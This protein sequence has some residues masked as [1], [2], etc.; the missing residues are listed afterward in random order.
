MFSIHTWYT[1]L[2]PENND[3]PKVTTPWK[4]RQLKATKSESNEVRYFRNFTGYLL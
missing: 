1:F 3:P 2:P 4:Q